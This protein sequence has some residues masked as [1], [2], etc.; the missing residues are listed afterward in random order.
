VENTN[1]HQTFGSI[2]PYIRGSAAQPA[3][4]EKWV[5]MKTKS[6]ERS[7]AE[8]RNRDG[9]VIA[10]AI[11]VMSEKGY[12]G[13]SIQEVA[14]RVGVLKGSLYHYFSSK[15]E[16]LFRILDESHS[17]SMVIADAVAAMGLDPIDELREYVTRQSLWYL[18]NVER[19][20][21]FFTESRNLTGERKALTKDR[22]LQFERHV[23]DLI[24]AGQEDGQIQSQLDGRLLT[25]F[26]IGAMNNV[27]FWPSR[28]AGSFSDAQLVS[29]LVELTFN[30]LE[31][32]PAAHN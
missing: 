28:S 21:I 15:E 14:D 19:A 7:S 12:S 20:N 23:R 26:V 18:A 3:L 16:L 30:G 22:G 27:R 10:A 5:I 31:A 8:G 11:S 17:E 6:S 13:T 24:T 2:F 9:N 1:K 4:A 32:Q 25:R 29:A